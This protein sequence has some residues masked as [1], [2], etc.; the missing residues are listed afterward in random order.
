MA[1][2]FDALEQTK[3]QQVASLE[4][5]NTQKPDRKFESYRS[6]YKGF[7][8]HSIDA[9][10]LAGIG[11]SLYSGWQPELSSLFAGLIIA[12]LLTAHIHW[13][14]DAYDVLPKGPII[15]PNR[16]HHFKPRE[17]IIRSPMTVTNQSVK[18]AAVAS[19]FSLYMGAPSQVLYAILFASSGNWVHQM[20]HHTPKEM[21]D[22][23][24][25]ILGLQ[26]LGIMQ[27]Y[28]QH[29]K[30]HMAQDRDEYYSI[31]TNYTNPVL[32]KLN[33]WK[34][35]ESLIEF[36]SKVKARTLTDEDS[37]E[38]NCHQIDPMKFKK[39]IDHIRR[40]Q[41]PNLYSD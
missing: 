9:V 15:C 12:D 20:A 4:L 38:L 17:I 34:N 13:L 10:I 21:K 3:G 23:S 1:A 28:A 27:S 25:I 7:P 32:A 19:L 24:Y 8:P 40:Q 36:I 35:L 39:S 29:R 6:Y 14:E 26:K 16:L 11:L 37:Y 2:E 18:A 22:I 33:Y 41:F 31:L 30:H 5:N